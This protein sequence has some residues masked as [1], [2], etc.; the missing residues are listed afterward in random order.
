M[1]FTKEQ[2]GD[3]QT[4][5]QVAVQYLEKGIESDNTSGASCYLLGRYL[6]YLP[7]KLGRDMLRYYCAYKRKLFWLDRREHTIF[8][9]DKK[10]L[11]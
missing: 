2:L 4:R 7:Y 10:I 1:F 5:L 3:R 6:I 8:S 9:S 11:L